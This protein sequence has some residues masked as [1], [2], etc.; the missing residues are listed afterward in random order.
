[1]ARHLVYTT[2]YALVLD[3][4]C[5]IAEGEWVYFSYFGT[6]QCVY[7][8]E[9]T[10]FITDQAGV[11]KILA[12]RPLRENVPYLEGVNVLPDFSVEECVENL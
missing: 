6:A 5:D 7:R 4:E 1:M 9:E 11:E 2:D 12:H 8:W 3:N 10:T